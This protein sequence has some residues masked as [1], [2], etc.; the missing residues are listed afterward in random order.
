MEFYK[1][2]LINVTIDKFSETWSHTL[3]TG[4]FVPPKYL[5]KLDK[6]IYQNLKKK[7]KEIEIYH[8]L[9]LQENGYKLSLFQK[10]KISMSGLKPLYF[11][12]KNN[13]CKKKN[14]H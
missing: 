8:L 13:N 9:Y 11:A 10:L 1:N 5:K 12:K 2:E 6:Y 7:F 3:D 4:D 14:T